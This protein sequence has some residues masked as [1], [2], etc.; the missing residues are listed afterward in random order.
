LLKTKNELVTIKLRR[1]NI[2]NLLLFKL[3]NFVTNFNLLGEYVW[4]DNPELAFLKPIVDAIEAILWPLLILVATA[5][6]I[7]AVILG[8]TMAKAE[9]ADKR[10]EAKKRII[11]AVLALV[12]TIVLILL[13]R[14]F[15]KELPSWIGV[16]Q[17]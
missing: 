3:A 6:T 4:E 7:Y 17:V 16:E 13:F 5:G 10:E 12:I 11:N 2:M 15:I 14:L 9:T 8:V 1:R